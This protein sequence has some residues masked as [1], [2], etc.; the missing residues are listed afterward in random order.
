MKSLLFTFILLLQFIIINAQIARVQV[1]HNSADAAASSVDVYLDSTK[2]IDDFAFRTAT[3]FIDVPAGT[4]IKISI[5][6]SNSIS[7]ADSIAVFNYNLT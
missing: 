3:P 6:P 7:V 4:P 1:I 2:I 5:A